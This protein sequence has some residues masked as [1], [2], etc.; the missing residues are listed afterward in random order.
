MRIMPVINTTKQ[1]RKPRR[2]AV[3]CG[4]GQSVTPQ[5]QNKPQRSQSSRK[6]SAD[7]WAEWMPMQRLAPLS[8]G[9]GRQ[10]TGSDR[11]PGQGKPV[12]V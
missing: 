3:R 6:T 7:Q 5:I 9:P 10:T 2:P 12:K 8:R 11:K 1:A 4:S